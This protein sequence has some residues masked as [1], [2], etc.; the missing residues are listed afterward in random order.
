MTIVLLLVLE[1]KGFQ[2][3]ANNGVGW[4]LGSQEKELTSFRVAMVICDVIIG[5]S[6]A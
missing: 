5:L 2:G 1:L 6:H 4:D 3:Q